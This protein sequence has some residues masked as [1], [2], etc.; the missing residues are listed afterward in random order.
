MKK[1]DRGRC[2][3]QLS[4]RDYIITCCTHWQ[5]HFVGTHVCMWRPKVNA[6]CLPVLLSTLYFKAGSLTELEAVVPD[7]LAGCKPPIP[8]IRPSPAPCTV[9]STST[10]PSPRPHKCCVNNLNL[11]CHQKSMYWKLGP[12]GDVLSWSNRPLIVRHSWRKLGYWGVTL[13]RIWDLNSFS[14][15]LHPVMR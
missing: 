2:V 5:T 6:T 11:K 10:E 9:S 13:K 1:G 8:R 14:L 3:N 15:F 4:C 12:L 7:L